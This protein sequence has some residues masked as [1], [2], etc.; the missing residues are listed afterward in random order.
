MKIKR[1]EERN[2]LDRIPIII[3]TCKASHSSA[4]IGIEFK[5]VVVDEATQ[6]TEIEILTA[7]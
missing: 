6:A 5:K 7:I 3:T 4:L 1:R 2:I